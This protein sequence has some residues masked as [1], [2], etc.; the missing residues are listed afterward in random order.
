MVKRTVTGVIMAGL[1][2]L[3]IWIAGLHQY[4]TFVFDALVLCFGAIASYEIYGAVKRA[5]VA[6]GDGTVGYKISGISLV[7]MVPATYIA[8]YFFGYTGI[9]LAFVVSFVTAFCIFIFDS[10]KTFNDF[11]VNTFALVYPMVM[12]GPVFVMFHRYGMIPVLL[13]LGI[14]TISDAMAYW[15][16]VLFGKKKIFPKISPKKTYA[17]CIGG[18]FGGALGGVIIYLIFELAGFPTYVKFTFSAIS[19]FPY[20]IYMLIGFILAFFS[21]IGD[22]AASR[23]KRSVGIKDYGKI[24]GSHGG[25]LDRIDSILF[26]VVCM[27]LIMGIVEVAL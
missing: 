18:L 3:I 13:A 26:T 11:T 19:R 2:F 17:G 8:S 25:I 1:L 5:D 10:N 16:G 12:L 24:L 21:E 14:S 20:L 9:L 7:V 22:L 15:V 4:A 27:A 6:R 23:V